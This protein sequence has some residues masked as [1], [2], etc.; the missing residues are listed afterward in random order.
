MSGVTR[1]NGA[2]PRL[3][4]GDVTVASVLKQRAH[5][6]GD[7]GPLTSEVTRPSRPVLSRLQTRV[8]QQVN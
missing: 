5:I 8:A 3:A 6:H 4:R 1:Q 2:G 7:L